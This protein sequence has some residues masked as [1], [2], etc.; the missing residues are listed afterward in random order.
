GVWLGYGAPWR[1]PLWKAVRIKGFGNYFESHS[2]PWTRPGNKIV[3]EQIDTVVFDSSQ[4]LPARVSEGEGS[5]NRF[6]RGCR[7]QNHHRIAPQH[8]LCTHLGITFGEIRKNIA[9]SS[10]R[11]HMTNKGGRPGG[12]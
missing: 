8:F 4:V 3:V 10:H 12:Q 7:A 9:A 5:S 6:S 1:L 11:N 2:Q